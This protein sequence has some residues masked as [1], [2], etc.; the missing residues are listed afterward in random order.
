[1]LVDGREVD[2]DRVGELGP[3]VERIELHYA[4]MS[5]VAPA[6][7]RYR[8][9]IDGFDRDWVDAGASRAAYYT[10]L[11]AGNYT[12][13]VI[14]SNNDGLWNNNG[15]S[16][17]F[18]L[19][20]RWYETL[21]FRTLVALATFGLLIAV[22]QLRVWRLRNRASAL[23]D[24]IAARTAALRSAN[25]E[26]TRLASLDGLTRIANRGAFDDRL[27]E[28]WSEHRRAGSPLAV[29]LCDIDAFKAYND[30]YGH[31]AGDTSLAAVAGALAQ[32]VRSPADLA[33]RYGGEEFALLL[34]DCGA[35]EAAGIAQHL[36]DTVRALQ[37]EHRS[38]NAAGHVTISIG[39]A[40]LVPDDTN[41]PDTLVRR[42]DEALYRAKAQ[43]RDRVCGPDTA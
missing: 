17:S 34:A 23:T 25:A 31:L 20:P 5:Y 16:I 19:L 15:A 22:Y 28:A 36:L 29:L 24:E 14:A 39:V 21:W 12:F 40:V 30:T 6:A 41:Q 3:G 37:I 18:A 11:P 32:R 26:L 7:V 27:A 33:A 1:M 4:G 43:G 2:P 35:A 13:R 42:A 38:S 9:R 10:N 8:Y